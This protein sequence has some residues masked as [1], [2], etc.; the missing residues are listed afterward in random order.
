M[1]MRQ[2]ASTALWLVV[3]APVGLA[4][5]TQQAGEAYLHHTV[6]AELQVADTEETAAELIAWAESGGGYLVYHAGADLILRLPESLRAGLRDY[7]AAQVD[8]LLDYSPAA[9][10]LRE[11]VSRVQAALI[12]RQEILDLNLGYLDESDV[13]ATLAL[14]QEIVRLLQ[15]I[16]SLRAQLT[17]LQRDRTFALVNVRLEALGQSLPEKRPSS[18]EWLNSLDL[19][20]F[21]RESDGAR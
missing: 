16:E 17:N 9:R 18:F 13:A 19:Y 4:Q 3:G 5:T 12:S 14:E 11:E 6:S 2:L 7:L 8:Y 20:R 15:E 1:K 10:D 21:L